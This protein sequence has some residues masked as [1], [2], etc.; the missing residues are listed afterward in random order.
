M[1]STS[2]SVAG[3]APAAAPPPRRT[4]WTRWRPALAF[5]GPAF[6]LLVVWYLYPSVATLIR[7]FFSDRGNDFVW[8][9]N[10]RRIFTDDIMLTAIKN[11][12]IW[13]VVVPAAVTALGL[14]F[15][16][17]TER[18][19]WSVAF[20]TV[21]FM[22][23]AVSAF[24]AGVT[25]RIMYQQDPDRGAINAAA[26]AVNGAFSPAGVL[27]EAAPS[28][29]ALKTTSGGAIELTQPVQPGEVAELG[30]TR[31]RSTEVP[32]TAKQA[33]QPE[34]LQGGITGVVW[35]DFKP[36]GGTPGE[37]EE[38][39]LGLP[40]VTVELTDSSGKKVGSAT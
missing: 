11:N 32:E 6:L 31:I 15:A 37:V 10:Y 26:A 30:L 8:F 21:V 36:G 40:G 12:A 9:D 34:P 25:W 14:I 5:I 27:S 22:P 1:T 29:D 23:M 33:L 20:K 17:L 7:S 19:S 24:A 2:A 18:V 35:R 3:Q 4:L 28:S 13:V 38:G 39:E 16:V